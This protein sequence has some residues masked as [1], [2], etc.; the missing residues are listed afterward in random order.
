MVVMV[1]LT[2]AVVAVLV[3][4]RLAVAVETV[5]QELSLFVTQ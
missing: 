4:A 1:E 2:L 5:A 3:E